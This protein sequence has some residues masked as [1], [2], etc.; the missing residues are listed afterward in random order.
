M[1]DDRNALQRALDLLE[2]LDLDLARLGL[3]EN[4]RVRLTLSQ[5]RE[6]L[7]EASLDLACAENEAR[8]AWASTWEA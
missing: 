4:D 8:E 5:A 6:E 3:D 7:G 1:T 2:D